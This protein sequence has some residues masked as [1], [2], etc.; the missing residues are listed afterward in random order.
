[1]FNILNIYLFFENNIMKI[2]YG[3]FH[4]RKCSIRQIRVYINV[5]YFYL[6]VFFFQPERINPP[7][8]QHGYDIRSDVWSLGITMVIN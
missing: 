6:I 3:F 1:M 4:F 8:G 5:N 2:K 7:K